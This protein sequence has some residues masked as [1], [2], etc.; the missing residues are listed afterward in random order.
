MVEMELGSRD[1]MSDRVTVKGERTDGRGGASV[2]AGNRGK[3]RTVDMRS[4]DQQE[5]IRV[6]RARL[7]EFDICEVLEELNK[8]MSEGTY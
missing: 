1:Q 2:M 4:L 3:T 6:S 7:D 5:D 8:K